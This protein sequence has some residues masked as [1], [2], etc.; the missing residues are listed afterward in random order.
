MF[1]S[2]LQAFS[3]HVSQHVHVIKDQWRTF[4][5]FSGLTALVAIV[6]THYFDSTQIANL[7]TQVGNQ[8][9]HIGFLQDRLSA[10][11]QSQAAAASTPPSQ[12]RRLSDR[13]R[14]ILLLALKQSSKE[15]PLLV[16]YAISDSEP[17]QYAA[18][19]VDVARIAGVDVRPR[20]VSFTAMVD[21]GIMIGLTTFPNPS[22]AAKKLKT[23]LDSAGIASRYTIW[24][25]Q[26]DDT[27]VDFD[28]FIGPKPWA[29]P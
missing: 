2:A 9:S 3:N 23:I 28:L 20:E 11:Q 19:F 27:S 22:E 16:I 5:A 24:A 12:W 29:S 8:Q 13:E 21:V 10:L 25:K 17:R 7:Q 4:A 15:L 14:D 18:Q 26:P 1:E 6:A